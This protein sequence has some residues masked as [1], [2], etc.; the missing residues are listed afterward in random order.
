MENKYFERYSRQILFSQIGVEGQEKLSK[1]R[2][3]IVGMGALGTV[4]AN[5]LT[6]SGVGFIR[7]IDRDFVEKSNLQ[8]QMLYDEYD[9]QES[10]PKAV[11]AYEKLI[12]INSSIEIEPVVTDIHAL[13]AEQ[14]LADVDVII[15]G[16]DN[17]LTRYTINDISIKY[18]IPWI[19]GAA[20]R[21]RGMFAV[22]IPNKGPCY[23][24]LFPNPPIGQSETC[25][26]VGVISAVTHLVGSYEAAEA[27]KL[28]V[29]DEENRNPNL[30]QFDIW[31]N[32]EMRMDISNSKNPKC[33]ACGNQEFEF[34]N[35]AFQGDEYVALCGRNSVQITPKN[36]HNVNLEK[37]KEILLNVGSV[38]LNPFLL[39]CHIDEI[40]IVLFN[41]GRV[42][43]QGTDDITKAKAIYA[44]YIG[45]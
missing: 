30:E 39:K 21:S 28:L 8:R 13:N 5:H 17:Y 26:M 43:V 37:T 27:L 41:N 10:K 29:Q 2:V 33:L 7:M 36:E 40:T 42:M 32:D 3:A 16:T 38:E 1:S 35:A 4:I 25:D 24:C 15:D 12:K 18:N 22:F 20:V 14:L 45:T 6:R 34:L 11:A 31:L 9:A 19:H 44:K 23:R